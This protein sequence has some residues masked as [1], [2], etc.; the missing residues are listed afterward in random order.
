M[1]GV[2]GVEMRVYWQVGIGVYSLLLATDTIFFDSYIASLSNIA[3]KYGVSD[4]N[5]ADDELLILSFKPDTLLNQES[6]FTKIGKCIEDIRK[7]LL[8]N[9]L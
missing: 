8:G 4:K 6:S 5:Y 1:P 7:F 9:K 2:I 3:L